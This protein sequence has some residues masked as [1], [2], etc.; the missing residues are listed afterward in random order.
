MREQERME[1]ATGD[2]GEAARNRLCLLESP[3]RLRQLPP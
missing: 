3:E 2:L 1:Q